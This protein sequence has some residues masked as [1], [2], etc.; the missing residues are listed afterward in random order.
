MNNLPRFFRTA[1]MSL[2]LAMLS[3]PA[4]SSS[5]CKGLA[6]QAC[7]NEASCTW[8]DSYK[9]SKGKTVESYCRSKPVKQPAK[10]TT[11]KQ[12]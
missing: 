3:S 4:M 7:S 5:D 12:G 2:G 11:D 9:T 10:T 8:I 1:M 6:E